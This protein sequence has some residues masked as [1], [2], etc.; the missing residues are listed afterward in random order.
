MKY[1]GNNAIEIDKRCLME[2]YERAVDEMNYVIDLLKT[3]QQ[4]N[5]LSNL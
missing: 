5:I 1:W 4:K 2:D 3:H